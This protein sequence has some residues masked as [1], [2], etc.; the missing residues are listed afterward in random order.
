[1]HKF[2][3]GIFLSLMVTACGGG[4]SS[5]KSPIE[6]VISTSYTNEPLFLKKQNTECRSKKFDGDIIYSL[7]LHLD[8]QDIFEKVDFSP[9]I[10]QLFLRDNEVIA[11]TNYGEKV[12]LITSSRGTRL[13]TLANPMSVTICPDEDHYAQGTVESAALN[14]AHIIKKTRTSFKRAVKDIEVAPITLNISPAIIESTIST[15]EMGKNVKTSRYWTDNALYMPDSKSITFLP[16]SQEMK[17]NGLTVNFWEVPMIASHEYGHHLFQSIYSSKTS[18]AHSIGCFDHVK[19]EK[20][21]IKNKSYGFRLVEIEKVM[22]AFNEGFA[23]LIAYYTLGTEERSV[24]GIMCLEVT[25]DVGSSTLIDGKSKVL[26]DSVIE[27]FFSWSEELSSCESPS[28]QEVHVFGAVI[29]HSM[30]RFMS[31]FTSSEKEKIQNIVAWI[32]FLNSNQKRLKD[33]KPKL[34]LTETMEAFI[35]NSLRRFKQ[36]T[37]AKTCKIVRSHF[38]GIDLPECFGR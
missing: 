9:L 29:A 1:M 2:F 12:E 33:L 20:S 25:R 22:T 4:S 28:Y 37:D 11:R 24:K 17:N 10:T 38:P 8:G 31:E 3:V 32:K 6:K 18:A 26:S 35:I 21:R 7:Y 13:L 27:T 34:F 15:N 36:S 16:H 5:N 30:E 19:K 14:A 23:D